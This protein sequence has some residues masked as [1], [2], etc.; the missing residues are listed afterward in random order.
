MN[1]PVGIEKAGLLAI[2]DNIRAGVESGDTLEGSIEFLQPYPP[3]DQDD[4]TALP[5]PDFMVMASYR[6]GNTM[7][8][9]GL[10][11]IGEMRDTEVTPAELF[12]VDDVFGI[13]DGR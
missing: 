8:Q 10:R 13:D 3:N 7:G 9:G 2:L 12:G 1:L 4:E 11:M 5:Q 6:I